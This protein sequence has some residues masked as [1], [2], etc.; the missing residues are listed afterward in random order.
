[1]KKKDEIKPNAQ[2][3]LGKADDNEMLFVLRAQDTSA[4]KVILHWMAKNFETVSE[5]RLREAFDCALE[6]RRFK[7]RKAAD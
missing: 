3:C 1:M 6:M 2:G 7:G 4:P 5:E